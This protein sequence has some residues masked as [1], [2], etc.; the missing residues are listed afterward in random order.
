MKITPEQERILNSLK[1]ERLCANRVDNL[2]LIETFSNEK[3]PNLV[4]IIKL[5]RTINRDESG[6]IAYYVVKAPSGEM[7]MYF[8]LKCGELFEALDLEKMVLAQKLWNAID[9]LQN[10]KKHE[11]EKVSEANEFI[12]KNIDEI[13]SI[14]P[15][16]DTYKRKKQFY[17][18][19][20]QKELNA[21]T[22]RVL[23]THPA[24]ELVEFC[25]NDAT[26]GVWNTLGLRRKMGECVFWHIIVPKIKELQKIVGC[27]Y[28]Y[29]FA[30]DK[31]YDGDLISYYKQVLRFNHPI[32][33]SA[34]KP[35]Y[36]FMCLFM[37]QAIHDLTIGRNEFYEHFNID[38]ANPV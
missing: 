25:A 24:V 23:A 2:R 7:L 15:N 20:L 26:R 32:E 28:L 10:P 13:K 33:L 16:I 4:K 12:D 31:S 37:C 29:L 34:N 30:A 3:N 18:Q 19:E 21:R 6:T 1:V 11:K 14:L 5:Q 35:E 38:D 17:E 8:S 22:Q 9:V 27:R 36:D